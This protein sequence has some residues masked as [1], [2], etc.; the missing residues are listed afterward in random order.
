MADARA[1]ELPAPED[2]VDVAALLA[3]YRE[4]PR[5]PVSFGTSGHRGTS[6]AG[7]FNE[8][9]VLA[10]TQAVC[11]HRAHHGIDG[12]LFVGADTHA[13]SAAALETILAV[14][15]ANGVRA[16]VDAD[17]RPIPTPLVSHAILTHNRTQGGTA[18]GIVVTP[19]HNPPEDGGFKYN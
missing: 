14:L 7:T 18:D 13:L 17:D 10:T 6:L 4:P 8:A 15:A 12:P 5:S 9:H 11:R 19:S 16:V 2:L 1:G 3:A